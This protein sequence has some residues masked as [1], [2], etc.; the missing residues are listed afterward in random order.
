MT[1]LAASASFPQLNYKDT[2]QENIDSIRISE[3][4]AAR[5]LQLHYKYGLQSL[6]KK[7]EHCLLQGQRHPNLLSHQSFLVAV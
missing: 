2:K 7:K 1:S 3:M 6:L 4:L 5:I